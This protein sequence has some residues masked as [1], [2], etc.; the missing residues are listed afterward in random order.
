MVE[1]CF[2]QAERPPTP[3]PTGY[4]GPKLVQEYARKMDIVNR[5]LSGYN[6]TQAL[7]V[8]P[9]IM[10]APE[11]ARVRMLLIFFGANDSRPPHEGPHTH[12][13]T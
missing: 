8:L 3:L 5:G 11:L 12:T 7:E 10:P 6:S 2:S 9:H 4:F 1:F 13:R